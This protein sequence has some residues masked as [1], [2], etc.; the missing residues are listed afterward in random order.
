MTP[1]PKSIFDK[2]ESAYTM[3]NDS[4]AEE[5]SPKLAAKSVKNNSVTG[6][7]RRAASISSKK[8][9][10]TTSVKR[11]NKTPA[12][13]LSSKEESDFKRGPAKLL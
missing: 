8:S 13:L 4:D 5:D 10:K 2:S 9:M 11:G 3:P 6:R 7:S 12:N 1:G